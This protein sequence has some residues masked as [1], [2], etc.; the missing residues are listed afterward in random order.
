MQDLLSH[1]RLKTRKKNKVSILCIGSGLRGDDAAGLLVA[2]SLGLFIQKSRLR[3]RVQVVS[4]ET[5]PENFTG[6]IRKFRPAH[7]ILIDSADMGC[8]AGEVRVIDPGSIAGM[9]F[10]THRLPLSV[11]IEYLRR[12][13]RCG[14]TVIGIQPETV[15]F[16]APVS[17]RARKAARLVSSVLKRLLK[18][19]R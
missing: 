8:C 2:R 6:L 9:S 1:L 3:H 19:K 16:A 15:V 14:V 17:S 4:G 12:S 7:I 18:E 10:C 11:M 13:M 5:A